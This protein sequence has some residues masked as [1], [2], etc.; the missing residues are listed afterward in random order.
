MK[1]KLLI[2]CVNILLFISS[3]E[4]SDYFFRENLSFKGE[5]WAVQDKIPFQFEISDTSKTYKIGFNIRYTNAYPQQ[6]L[7]V[8]LHTVLPDGMHM[9]DTISVD[10][11]SI[12][13]NP[14]GK[15]HRVI[16]LQTYF[17]R[18]RFPMMGEYTITLEQ[19]M[20]LDTLQGVISM[21]LCIRE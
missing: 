15:G 11:F 20:R 18:V 8:F 14:L 5:S 10:L 3:C 17:S 13:G 1:N 4:N 12:E 6:N 21:G 19:A 9:H 7:Y 2:L 16:E